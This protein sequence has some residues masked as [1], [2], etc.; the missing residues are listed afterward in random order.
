MPEPADAKDTFIA[1][2]E[3][4]KFQ[5]IEVTRKEKPD[6]SG[7]TLKGSLQPSSKTHLDEQSIEI[8]LTK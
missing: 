1:K 6:G 7:I 2:V 5:K 8:T 3:P 4:D